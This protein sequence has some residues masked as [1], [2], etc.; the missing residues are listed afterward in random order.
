MNP[1]RLSDNTQTT[2]CQPVTYKAECYWH[3]YC[4]GTTHGLNVWWE[5]APYREPVKVTPANITLRTIIRV[6][7]KQRKHALISFVEKSKEIFAHL[8]HF[9]NATHLC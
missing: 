3:L 4:P 1:D 2:N 7:F 6:A 5:S 8:S 9:P